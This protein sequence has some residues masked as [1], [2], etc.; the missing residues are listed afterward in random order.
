MTRRS[1]QY[2]DV[3]V[4]QTRVVPPLVQI[5]SF[6][7]MFLD[8]PH[9]ASRYYRTLYERVPADIFNSTHKQEPY[10]TS[11]FT[12]YRLDVN[13]RLRKLDATLKPARYLFLAAFRELAMPGQL[14]PPLNSAAMVKYCTKLNDVLTQEAVALELFRQAGSLILLA[15]EGVVSRD[16]I[17]RERL[18]KDVLALA[19]KLT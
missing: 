4:E 9:S 13:F 16:K 8:E 1:R 6:A 12:W 18:T 7:A 19:R 17:K 15:S 5:R 11:A 3:A 10:Y 2:A 14:V